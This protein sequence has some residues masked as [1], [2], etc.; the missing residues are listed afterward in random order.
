MKAICAAAMLAASTLP[1]FAGDIYIVRPNP[2]PSVDF[3]GMEDLGRNIRRGFE[4]MQRENIGRLLAAGDYDGA[5]KAAYEAGMIETGMQIQ[6][7]KQQHL[8]E[9]R[10]AGS[11]PVSR[12]R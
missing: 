1:A 7:L 6:A 12:Q 5:A 10:S 2:Y 11:R 3:S 4:R 8:R 9:V